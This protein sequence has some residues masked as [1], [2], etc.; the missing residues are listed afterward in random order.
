MF[1]RHPMERILSCYLDKMVFSSH[2]S[3]PAFR[4]LVKQRG[5][6]L[7]RQRNS[8]NNQIANATVNNESPTFQEFLEYIL[9]TDL[10]GILNQYLIH[11]L[12]IILLSTDRKLIKI[13]L[14]LS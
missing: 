12:R 1:V 6:Q 5:I 7:L 10:Q 14:H 13:W 8:S 4:R 9:S 3:L 2:K 11:A